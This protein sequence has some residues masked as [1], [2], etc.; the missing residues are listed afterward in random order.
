MKEI[1]N[2]CSHPIV[3]EDGTVLAAAG[4]K[5]SVKRVDKLTE[6]EEKRILEHG[7]AHIND[8]PMEEIVARDRN[9]RSEV[10]GQKSDKSAEP[11]VR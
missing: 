1:I 5:G 6:R 4:T 10:R 3:L 8:L 7:H 9:Q 2:R 11:E